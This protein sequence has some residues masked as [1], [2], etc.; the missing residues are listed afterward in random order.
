MDAI[1]CVG[2]APPSALL[3]R[4]FAD[5]AMV[6]ALHFS[7]SDAPE[8][9]VTTADLGARAAAVLMHGA[10]AGTH[11]PM[12]AAPS[13]SELCRLGPAG[14][15]AGKR[16]P[17]PSKRVPTTYIITDAATFR[18]MVQQVTGAGQE[19]EPQQ[20]GGAGLGLLLPHF[21]VEPLPPADPAAHVAAA[22]T[23]PTPSAAEQPL[24]PTLDS[25]NVMYGKNE[26]V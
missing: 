21:S 17:R 3:S 26:V 18:L 23:T 13:A 7:L 2:V 20:D 4:S 12:G 8:P 5:A 24:F 9:S 15:R 10:G 11:P 19:D 1:S 16:R 25:W 22:Y 14:R 6:R